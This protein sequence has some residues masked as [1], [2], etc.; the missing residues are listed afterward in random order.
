MEGVSYLLREFP[1]PPPVYKAYLV[2]WHTKRQFKSKAMEAFELEVRAWYARNRAAC[3]MAEDMLGDALFGEESRPEAMI[4]V[5]AWLGF[6]HSNMFTKDWRRKKMDPS[7]RIKP[8]HDAVAGILDIDDRHFCVGPTEP[9]MI[10]SE[11]EC[12]L[13]KLTVVTMEKMGTVL[14]RVGGSRLASSS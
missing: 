11:C 8:L 14:E 2:N 6:T 4:Q 9:V 5:S 13:V 1:M 10:E 12:V 3:K 7:N